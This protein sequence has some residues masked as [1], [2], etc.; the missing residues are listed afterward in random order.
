MIIVCALLL[1]ACG[2]AKLQEVRFSERPS[3]P[4]P[5]DDESRKLHDGKC[6]LVQTVTYEGAVVPYHKPVKVNPFFRERLV[7]FE[8]VV[9]ETAEDVLG[10]VPTAIVHYGTYNCR[11]IRGKSKMSEHGLANAIDVAGFRF[12]T[13]DIK[14]KRDWRAG[15]KKAR[16]LHE[17]AARLAKRPDIF[18][19]ILGPDAPGHDDHF[20]FDCGRSRY[21]RFHLERDVIA[22]S[23][24]DDRHARASF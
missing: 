7:Q 9:A 11:R 8:Q 19:G 22:T 20:H 17:I 12:E 14:V 6:P 16:F 2:S 3:D 15:D 13:F 18:R 21:V 10:E 1:S 24:G 4:Y 5:L 23:E